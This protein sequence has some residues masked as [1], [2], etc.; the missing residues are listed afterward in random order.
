MA[1]AEA[2]RR[3]QTG[4]RQSVS[5]EFLTMDIRQALIDL[6]KIVGANVDGRYYISNLFNILYW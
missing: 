6:G 1:S 4:L 3:V 2:A 5:P